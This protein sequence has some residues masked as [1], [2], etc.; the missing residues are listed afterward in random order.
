MKT[1]LIFPLCAV[2]C[3]A[4]AWAQLRITSFKPNDELVWTNPPVARG[5]YSVESADSPAGPWSQVTN[6]AG[7]DWSLYSSL[8]AQVPQTDTH[9]F[10][11]VVWPRPDPV[12]VWDYRGYD[13]EGALVVTGQ[14]SIGSMTL[15]SSNPPVGYGVHG[16]WNLQYA[17]PETNAPWWI[18]PQRG[19][20]SLGGTLELHNA[21][22]RLVWPTNTYDFNIQLLNTLLGPNTYTGIW[23]YAT[24]VGPQG[25]PFGATRVAPPTNFKATSI[26]KSKSQN[27]V[28]P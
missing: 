19:T 25:G 10:Y 16:S 18:G 14:L 17:G 28:Q 6:V 21:S 22:L 2:L 8:A 23:L 7:S 11:R 24:W 5:F 15:L 20:G 9:A 13:S 26:P 27:G 4:A 1:R 3:G 12:G